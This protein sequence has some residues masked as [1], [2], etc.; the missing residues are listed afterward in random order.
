MTTSDKVAIGALGLS[1]ISVVVTVT[2]FISRGRYDVDAL[3]KDIGDPSVPSGLYGQV[4]QAKSNAL[5]ATVDAIASKETS[6]KARADSLEA[7]DNSIKAKGELDVVKVQVKTVSEKTENAFQQAN[8]A[9][10]LAKQASDKSSA[11]IMAA[12]PIGTILPWDP[13]IRDSQ[14]NDTKNRRSVPDGWTICGTQ[15][16]TPDLNE[17]FIMGVGSLTKGGERG[18][19]D[20]IDGAP[21][22]HT[23]TTSVQNADRNRHCDGNCY[24]PTPAHSH[25]F[26]TN[27]DGAHSHGTNRPT[28]YSVVFLCKL[29]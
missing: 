9:A 18:G 17:S 5:K 27:L 2:L 11:A 20:T 24:A 14:N 10:D 21:H 19:K 8:S 29:S 13:V 28:Y 4:D 23:G 16:G 6:E 12:V 22:T 3:R 15:G 25:T 26:T 1:I 7:R